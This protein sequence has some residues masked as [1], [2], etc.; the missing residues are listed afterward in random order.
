MKR[1]IILLSIISLCQLASMGQKKY[2]MVIEKKDGTSVVI[3]TE[4]IN[5]TFFREVTEDSGNTD[6]YD[7]T[8]NTNVD[9]NMLCGKWEAVYQHILSSTTDYGLEV[10][11]FEDYFSHGE[12]LQLNSDFTGEMYAPI[13]L[14]EIFE[15]KTGKDGDN[16]TWTIKDDTIY[17]LSRNNKPR[18]PEEVEMEAIKIIKLTDTEMTLYQEVIQ[19][20]DNYIK[21]TCKFKK[22]K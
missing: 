14:E 20:K 13:S 19:D 22:A 12:Y 9:L 15:W 17:F 11:E 16:L 3:K 8:P 6:N 21:T 1:L 7:S 5:R 10:D 4:D 2:E 18:D